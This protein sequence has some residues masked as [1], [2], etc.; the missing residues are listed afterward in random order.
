[1]GGDAFPS[2]IEHV[3][4]PH[5]QIVT[6]LSGDVVPGSDDVFAIVMHGHF[7]LNNVP[8]PDDE[9]APSGSVLTVVIDA[10]TGEVTDFAVQNQSRIFQVLAP[11]RRTSSV[12]TYPRA[13]SGFGTGGL[14][15]AG[16][17]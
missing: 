14:R 16:G 7:A 12:C 2:S 11:L 6:T 1:V 5:Q 3:E 13:R 9:P 4:G 8:V 15:Q 17:R 10:T